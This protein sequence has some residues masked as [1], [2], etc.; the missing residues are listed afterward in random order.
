MLRVGREK[1]ILVGADLLHV[2]LVE[3]GLHVSV[4][5]LQVSL[6]VGAAGNLVGQCSGLTSSLACS[7]WR[8]VGNTCASS[9]GRASFGHSR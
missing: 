7:K 1:G 6:G 2:E 8:V 9:P 5:R 4:D 3:P